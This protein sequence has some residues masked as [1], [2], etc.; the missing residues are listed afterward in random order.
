M[1]KKLFYGVFG[2]LIAFK[3]LGLENSFD[4]DFEYK[5]LMSFL[6]MFL[7]IVFTKEKVRNLKDRSKNG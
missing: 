4:F 5:L 1:I 7:I 3:L 6:F 2:G